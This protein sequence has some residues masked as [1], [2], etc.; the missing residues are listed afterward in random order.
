MEIVDEAATSVA[1]WLTTL[2]M[3]VLIVT[4]DISWYANADV[5]HSLM[6][7]ANCTFPT[8]ECIHKAKTYGTTLIEDNNDNYWLK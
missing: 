3:A 7:E 6:A 5:S 4:N 1:T 8:L 2:I